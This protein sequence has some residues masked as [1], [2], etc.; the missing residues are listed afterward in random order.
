MKVMRRCL[1]I[2]VVLGCVL[3]ATTATAQRYGFTDADS[4]GI[5]VMAGSLGLDGQTNWYYYNGSDAP[6]GGY[7]GWL[8][9]GKGNVTSGTIKLPKALAPGRY[10]I[11][12]WGIDYDAN[13]TLQA[14]IGGAT[15][16]PILLNDRDAN[17][18][19]SDKGILDVTTS[20]DVLTI[21]IN[22]NL[23]IAGDQKYLLEGIYITT[24]NEKTVTSDG[25]AVKLIY[26]TS[27]DDSAAVKGNLIPNSGFE[28]PMDA[29]WGFP[30]GQRTIPL[31]TMWDPTQGHSGQGALK[32]TFESDTRINPANNGEQ[33]IS[34]VYHVK[35]NK[36]YTASMWVKT[37]S[38]YYSTAQIALT[39][40]YIPPAGFPAQYSIAST[41]V[42]IGGTWTRVSVTGYLLEYPTSDYQIVLNTG[43][44]PG[45]YVLVDD[46]QLEEG[47]LTDY[48][49]AAEVE[50]GLL[51]DTTVKPGNIY[52]T[53]EP[54][55][56]TLVVHNNTSSA[57]SKVL[58]YEIYD[59]LNRIVRQGSS[60]ISI[61][62]NTTQNT[63]FDIS[64]GGKQGAFRV[65]TW[66]DGDGGTER[67]SSYSIIPRPAITGLDPTS[68]I[69][70]H[71]NYTDAQLKMLQRLGMKW[72]RA[73]SP[74]PIC[75]WNYIEPVE[76]QFVWFDKEIQMAN[77]YGL[78]TMCTIGTNN[79]W[80]AWAD[81]GGLPDLNKWQAFVTALVT[82]YKPYVKH[83][84]IWNE[85]YAVFTPSFYAQMLKV[86][87]EAIVAVDPA[88][89]IIGMGGDPP[90]YI[91]SV[92]TSM[93]TQFPTWDWKQHIAVL[94][95]HDY[96]DG[97]A[98]ESLKTIQTTYG[99]QIWNT[100][101]GAW[102][103]G[104]YQ[105]VNSNFVAWGKN[106]WPHLDASRYYEGMIGA[107]DALVGNFLRTIASGQ[108]NYFYYDSRY[109]ASPNYFKHHPTLLEYDGTV[110]V[111]GIAYAIAG[112]L[113]DHSSPLGNASP[114]PN[115][116]FLVFD[117]ATGPV[118]ALFSADKKPKQ[119]TLPTGSQIQVLDLMGNPVSITGTTVRYGRIPVYVKGLGI[120]AAALKT[121]LQSGTVAAATDVT[122]PNVSISD[123]PR[124]KASGKGF[125]ARWIAMDESSYPNLGEINPESNIPSDTP[126]PIAILYTYKLEGVSTWSV[127]SPRTYVDFANLADGTYTLSVQ[128]K[129]SAGNLSSIVSR[130]IVVGSGTASSDA[131]APVPANSG[132]ISASNVGPAG[133]TLGWAKATDNVSV[134]S[135]LQY[136]VRRSAS[137]NIATVAM[138]EA[139]G[140]VVQAYAADLSSL[141]VT[142]LSAS[143]AYFFN[144]IVKDEAG[145][146]ASYT[147]VTATTTTGP[148]LDKTPPAASI[149]AP[150]NGAML[151][152]TIT[153]SAT[154]SGVSIAGV[155]FRLDGGDLGA[156]VT[157]SP[158]NMSWNTREVTNGSHQLIAVARD[159][160][161]N[162]AASALVTVTV[163]N[164]AP[165]VAIASPVG[166]AVV[167]GNVQISASASDNVGVVGVQ[168]L[169]DGAN[170]GQEV[171]AA[172]YTFSWN[173]GSA[174]GGAHTLSAI[175]RDKSGNS[176]AAPP[177][178]VTVDNAPP[179]LSITAPSA[180]SVVKGILAVTANASDDSGIA[181]VQF[182]LDGVNLGSEVT[183]APYLVSW[184]TTKTPRG[185]HT[186][187]AVARDGLG[188]QVTSNP[189]TVTV[190]NTGGGPTSFNVPRN[191][192]DVYST[193]GTTP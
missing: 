56:T 162:L 78:T 60:N 132:A 5:T 141:V 77:S 61:S 150:A 184:D 19:W 11:F 86:A 23:A 144:V 176:A 65:V 13:K 49:V 171:T 74:A 48:A 192:V 52:Y 140:T 33:I 173:A 27:M 30:A 133:L 8:F 113:V 131:T 122:A 154:A 62:A 15:S 107:A 16:G 72:S 10:Y 191:G 129:D 130:S 167:E 189:V 102:D 7:N 88:A 67:E 178:T 172:P 155:Q 29:S 148:T 47:D 114:D 18:R 169:L 68:F 93:Q 111:K 28:V 99:K 2:V 46:V 104:F 25:V 118:A 85:P 153:L 26:P 21:A 50:A 51:L 123:A 90:D 32:L 14:S 126:D 134:Q 44:T 181:G 53:D 170:L 112:A 3:W 40:P 193:I 9:S 138:A 34:R 158:Y 143:T 36:K 121:A 41:A 175:A 59:F 24:N 152:G 142:G 157:A 12:F 124:G 136:E 4:E 80:P 145:N 39:N 66:I 125:R 149:T 79:Y 76:N 42:P 71:P 120:T 84:E 137:N 156:E 43:G 186:L 54:L 73:M 87:T 147:T 185:S 161:G 83:W 159:A 128:A 110:R 165:S 75:R 179:S 106:L 55:S 105:G 89:T 108:T 20:S 100:E 45:N 22:R 1:G 98:P 135:T 95:T 81:N 115:S 96:P 91:Q 38:G 188:R 109:Y 58:R 160:A 190:D 101:T 127:W 35:P 103:S 116:Y 164:A 69:G 183:S 82:H 166:G 92:I 31:N 70:I 17:G 168:F 6:Q 187:T 117:K 64:T 174:K 119:V 63:P 97:V 163:D 177:V 180:G 37:N 146:K 182:K 151:A 94:S 139:N 57:K